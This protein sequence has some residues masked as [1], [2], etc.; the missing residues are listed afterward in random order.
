MDTFFCQVNRGFHD[1][2]LGSPYIKY[3]VDLFA[4]GLEDNPSVKLSLSDKRRA[5]KNTSRGGVISVPPQ[6]GNERSPTFLR[7]MPTQSSDLV[8]TAVCRAQDNPSTSA[9]VSPGTLRKEWELSL[10]DISPHALAIDPHVDA[11]AVIEWEEGS[12]LKQ[13]M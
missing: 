9:L 1:F 11:L 5:L 4:S 13:T 8:F 10:P 12:L 3:R 7:I 6:G 2:I